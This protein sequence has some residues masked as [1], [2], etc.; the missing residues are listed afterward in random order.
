MGRGATQRRAAARQ[1][2]REDIL[3][4]AREMIEQEGVANLSLRAIARTLGYSP[5][6][7]YEYFASK[8]AIAKALYFEGADGLAGQMHRDLADLSPATPPMDAK[9]ALGRAYRRY[10]L[11]NRELFLLVF[12]SGNAFSTLSEQMEKNS[13]GYDAL[14]ATVQSGLDSGDIVE[15]PVEML[16]LTAWASVHGFVMLELSGAFG[17]SEPDCEVPGQIPPDQLFEAHMELIDIGMRRR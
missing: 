14:L 8:E 4:A 5:A 12:G 3:R 1:E 13:E 17:G 7:L 6:A 11:D 16:A 2:M 15:M 9:K 10:A